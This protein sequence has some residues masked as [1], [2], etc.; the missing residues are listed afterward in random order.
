MFKSNF[1]QNKYKIVV[2][3]KTNRNGELLKKTKRHHQ[4]NIGR[5]HSPCMHLQYLR[6]C[7]C[8]ASI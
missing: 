5:K 8:H 7:V 1:T 6:V 4:S 2:N 3:A